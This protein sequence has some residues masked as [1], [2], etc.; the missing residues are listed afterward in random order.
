MRRA[1]DDRPATATIGLEGE[2]PKSMS[3]ANR[4]S[5]SSPPICHSSIKW[6]G[7]MGETKWNEIPRPLHTITARPSYVEDIFWGT[8]RHDSK[9]F[10][11]M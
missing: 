10:D 4:R 2:G 6:R 11:P 3:C 9:A 8:P 1:P 5:S 7:M